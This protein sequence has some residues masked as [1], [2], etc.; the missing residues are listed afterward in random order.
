MEATPLRIH[1]VFQGDLQ[2]LLLNMWLRYLGSSP[3]NS[4]LNFQVLFR[5]LRGF[6]HLP[7]AANQPAARSSSL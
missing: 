6:P 5:E 3:K 1:C 4:P 2:K 7:A